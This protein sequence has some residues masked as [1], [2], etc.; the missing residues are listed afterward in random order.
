ML[1]F[2]KNVSSVEIVQLSP[3]IDA[4]F[5]RWKK[6]DIWNFV[7]E[8]TVSKS[9]E[10]HQLSFTR[11]LLKPPLRLFKEMYHKIE[12]NDDGDISMKQVVFH[13]KGHHWQQH[14]RNKTDENCQ[15]AKYFKKQFGDAV[16]FDKHR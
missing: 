5:C 7:F 12:T 14:C 13:I 10:F 8:F 1:Y 9:L 6:G 4:I 11:K 16:T 2:V 15:I 3:E